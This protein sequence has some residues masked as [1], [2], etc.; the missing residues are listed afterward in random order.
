MKDMKANRI[1][2]DV[3]LGLYGFYDIT[4][5]VPSGSMAEATSISWMKKNYI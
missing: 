4:R 2:P 5:I 1:A 3:T